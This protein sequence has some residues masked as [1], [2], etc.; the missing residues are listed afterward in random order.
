MKEIMCKGTYFVMYT[1]FNLEP[2]KGSKRGCNVEV[3]RGAGDSAGK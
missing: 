2:E 3:L 1:L